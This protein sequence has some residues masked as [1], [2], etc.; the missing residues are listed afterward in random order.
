MSILQEKFIKN[1]AVCICAVAV[2]VFAFSSCKKKDEGK[3]KIIATAGIESETVTEQQ[4]TQE[5]TTGF[6]QETEAVTVSEAP[7]ETYTVS[8]QTEKPTQTVTNAVVKITETTTEKKKKAPDETTTEKY[9]K[10]GKSIFS[11]DKNNKYLKAVAKKY[12]V[13]PETLACVYTVPDTNGNIVLQFDGSVDKNNRYIRN[14]DTLIAIYTIDKE[15]NSKRAS[16]DESLNEYE[17]G[18]MKTMFFS[19]GNWIIPKFETELNNAPVKS[20]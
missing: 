20:K 13:L 3:A 12:N 7:A 9:K 17:Y 4:T 19:V 2:F 16:N 15:L 6:S 1:S 5:N 18:E 8:V 14:N 11:D 10:T